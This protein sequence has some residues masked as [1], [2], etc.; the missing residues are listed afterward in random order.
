[1]CAPALVSHPGFDLGLAH[2]DGEEAKEMKMKAEEKKKEKGAKK[3][4]FD[5]K[6]LQRQEPEK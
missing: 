4:K 2:A 6:K 1:L 3:L 5:E